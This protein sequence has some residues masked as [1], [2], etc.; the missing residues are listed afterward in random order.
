MKIYRF[1]LIIFQFL[2]SLP[3]TAANGDATPTFSLSFEC[4]LRGPYKGM[5]T[6][7]IG[8]D[9]AGEFAV[10][11]EDS[12]LL[13]DTATGE[14]IVLNYPIEPGK[15]E[16]A[17]IVNVGAQKVITWK[18]IL[19]DKLYVITAYDNPDI[20]DCDWATPAPTMEATPNV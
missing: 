8:Y 18:V 6:A 9:Y 16:Q 3:I 2:L 12:R 17:L 19:F 5:A 10:T 13:G 14:T 11:P 20:P 15:H 1:C 7:Y 4:V